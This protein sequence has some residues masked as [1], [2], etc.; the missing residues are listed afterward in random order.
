LDLEWG[1]PSIAHEG[2]TY[3]LVLRAGDGDGK[4]CFL[5]VAPLLDNLDPGAT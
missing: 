5:V 1:N 2:K 4:F 3:I